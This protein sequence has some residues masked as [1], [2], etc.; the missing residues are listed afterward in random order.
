MQKKLL[1]SAALL[2]LVAGGA[3]AQVPP[4]AAPAGTPAGAAATIPA[5]PVATEPVSV[6]HAAARRAA[7][8]YPAAMAP[9]G[10][11]WRTGA[12]PYSPTA[13]NINQAD[14]RSDIAPRLPAPTVGENASPEQFLLAAQEALHMRHSGL[15]QEALERA[16]TRL[17]DRA[18][19]PSAAGQPD[20][21][22]R[23]AM[24]TQARQA[25]GNGDMV[26]AERLVA[27]ALAAGGTRMGS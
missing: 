2:G 3:S 7:A 27:Q 1:A 9:H 22:P 17:L 12:E 16:E 13:S 14:T 8:H 21:A 23:I 10:G 24:I 26:T 11:I 25:L 20:G 5:P 6:P 4:A 18:T 19:V 15:A